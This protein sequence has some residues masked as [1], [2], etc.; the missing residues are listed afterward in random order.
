MP[1]NGFRIG[2]MVTFWSAAYEK[3]L[4]GQ[5]VRIWDRPVNDPYV[6]ISVLP[7]RKIFVRCTSAITRAEA[8]LCNTVCLSYSR[9]P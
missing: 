7:E 4:S 3:H 6:T 8:E 1:D 9:L 2:D 5:I